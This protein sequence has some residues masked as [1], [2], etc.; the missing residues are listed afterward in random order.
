M[1]NKNLDMM[2]LNICGSL[3]KDQKGE[4]IFPGDLLIKNNEHLEFAESKFNNTPIE[5]LILKNEYGEMTSFLK[6]LPFPCS[7]YSFTDDICT[8]EYFNIDVKG[9]KNPI[10]AF[11][12]LLNSWLF[13]M[14]HDFIVGFNNLQDYTKNYKH[15]IDK[16]AEKCRIGISSTNEFVKNDRT[17]EKLIKKLTSQ[18][19]GKAEILKILSIKEKH[20]ISENVIFK[21]RLKDLISYKK[22]KK[23]QKGI[24]ERLNWYKNFDKIMFPWIHFYLRENDIFE[25]A[26]KDGHFSLSYKNIKDALNHYINI[27]YH[28]EKLEGYNHKDLSIFCTKYKN[29]NKRIYFYKGK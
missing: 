20:C 2:S 4:I 7:L 22:A 9:I 11:H 25:M 27:I 24:I 18:F 15:L 1:K 14:N 21:Y 16:E 10:L 6:S 23:F 8:A 28:Y 12:G 17:I 19:S 26:L 5:K 13:N 29:S 3:L